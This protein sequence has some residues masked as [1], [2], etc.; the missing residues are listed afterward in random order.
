MKISIATKYIVV[1]FPSLLLFVM[2]TPGLEGADTNPPEG[3]GLGY[4]VGELVTIHDVKGL[5]DGLRAKIMAWHNDRWVVRDGKG[6]IWGITP[7]KLKRMTSFQVI[8]LRM[9]Y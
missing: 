1:I 8:Y 6:Q 7:E 9:I 2:A 5:E 3:T 4:K